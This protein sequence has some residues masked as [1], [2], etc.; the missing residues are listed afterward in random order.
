MKSYA[1][2]SII[3]R[4]ILI[5]DDEPDLLKLMKERLEREGFTV[6]TATNANAGFKKI[7]EENPELILLDVMMP[8]K[9]GFSMLSELKRKGTM[10]HIPVIILSGKSETRSLFEG[11]GLGATDYLIKPIEF[12]EL[13]RTIRR[14]LPPISL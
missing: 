5:V 10:F 13:I 6:V 2:K 7:T 1:I 12:K 4:K 11:Q 3:P 8:D 14:Y 9:D